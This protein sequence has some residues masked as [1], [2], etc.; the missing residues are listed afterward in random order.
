MVGVFE[1]GKLTAAAHTL[2]K[3][4]HGYLSKMAKSGAIEG[5]AGQTLLLFDAQAA[6]RT[7]VAGGAGL[8]EGTQPARGY[9]KAMQ[10]TVRA[11]N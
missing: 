8:G 3:A 6:R 11:L 7:R 10:K 9:R 5:R 2:D 4:S 1:G